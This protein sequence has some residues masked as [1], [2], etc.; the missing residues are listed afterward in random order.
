[1]SVRL[2]R[3]GLLVAFALAAV[4][5][6][7]AYGQAQTQRLVIRQDGIV[8]ATIQVPSAVTLRLGTVFSRTGQPAS[9]LVHFGPTD[10]PTVVISVTHGATV[11]LEE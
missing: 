3:I 2:R 9:Q 4:G 8:L 7:R 1:M 5:A 6:G 11:A 10:N